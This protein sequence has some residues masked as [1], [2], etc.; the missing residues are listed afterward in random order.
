MGVY[1]NIL[2]HSGS[3]SHFSPFLDLIPHLYMFTDE[4]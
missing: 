2:F 3:P 4:C 1:V